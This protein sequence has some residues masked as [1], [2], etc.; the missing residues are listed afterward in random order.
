M[1]LKKVPAR[2]YSQ[3]HHKPKF[4]AWLDI[5]H[6]TGEQIDEAADEVARS[7]DIDAAKGHALDVIGRIVDI[8]RDFINNIELEQFQ[9]GDDSEF[10]D[11]NV[12]FS[13]D[14]V[15][16]DAQMSDDLFRLLIKSKILKN[17]REATIEDIIEQM[18]LLVDAYFV[19]INNP[20]DMTFSIEFAADLTPLQRYALFNENIIQIP[21]GVLFNGFTE[22]FD[23]V[24]FGDEDRM[25]G[26]ENTIFTPLGVV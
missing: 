12:C 16:G 23:Y 15:A 10:G 1:T 13:A 20:E 18:T 19:R 6:K 11:E 9:F 7:Y 22:L 3:Y 26:E 5:R 17:N 24:E 25:F 4:E 2:N 21:Q 14:S 8:N